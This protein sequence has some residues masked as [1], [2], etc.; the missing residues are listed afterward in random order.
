MK[1]MKSVPMSQAKAEL[2]SLVARGEDHPCVV[3]NRGKPVALIVPFD[4]PD[5]LL[6]LAMSYS[7]KLQKLVSKASEELRQGGGIPE[8]EFWKLVEADAQKKQVKRTHK[9]MKSPKVPA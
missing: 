3:T 9:K 4:D 1:T 6:S 7:P 2:H 8:Q 5:D